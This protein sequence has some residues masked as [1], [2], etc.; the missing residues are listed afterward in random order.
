M[1]T[2]RPF[3]GIIKRG[4]TGY[5]PVVLDRDQKKWLREVFPVTPNPLIEREMGITHPTLYRLVKLLGIK[6]SP[7]GMKAIMKNAADNHRLQNKHERLRLMSG[8]RQEK[9]GN[10]RI[11]AYTKKQ[12]HCRYR[13]VS[14]YNYIIYPGTELKD[15]DVDRYK[16]FYDGDTQRSARFEATCQRYGLTIEEYKQEL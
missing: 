9:C 6:K 15:H 13:A 11:K 14:L 7:E 5:H 2:M 8:Q 1:R 10:I 4:K 12:I 3:P 16:I